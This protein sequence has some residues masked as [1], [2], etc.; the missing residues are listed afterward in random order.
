MGTG[1]G[2][3]EKSVRYLQDSIKWSSI[4]VL[5]IQGEEK[6]RVQKK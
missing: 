4:H 1:E 6:R 5:G 2:Q 3:M